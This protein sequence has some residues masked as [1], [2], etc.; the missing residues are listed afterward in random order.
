MNIA[1]ADT[2]TLPLTISTSGDTPA[3]AAAQ[4]FR[5]TCGALSDL[6]SL[7]VGQQN[8]SLV[9]EQIENATPTAQEISN[10]LESLS[11]RTITSIINYTAR[12]PIASDYGRIS[13]FTRLNNLSKPKASNS[14]SR[15][16]KPRLFFQSGSDSGSRWWEKFN[17]YS[18]VNST[19]NEQA[20]TQRDAKS[21]G[22]SFG[23]VIGAD[24]ALRKNIEVGMAIDVSGANFDVEQT[25]TLQVRRQTMVGYG[26]LDVTNSWFIETA[27]SLS[28]I[29]YELTR[30]IDF[31]LAQQDFQE[32][33]KSSSRGT[34]LN[35]SVGTGYQFYL[36]YGT[37]LVAWGDLNA[38]RTQVDSFQEKNANGLGLEI[39]AID[40]YVG[41]WRLGVDTSKPLY[42]GWGII[43]P[44]LSVLYVSEFYNKGRPVS[45]EFVSDPS[46]NKFNFRSDDRD[47]KYLDINLGISFIFQKGKSAYV[48]YRKYF[49]INEYSQSTFSLGFR[50]EF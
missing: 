36:P 24:T 5:N 42:Q 17:F 48:S 1:H 29:S 13:G 31:S 4:G 21:V 41:Q 18:S 9:C 26:S 12:T 6:V 46:D 20:R 14:F 11:A 33:A 19:S 7:D 39:D 28:N 44:Q 43:M 15:N 2:L 35:A 34:Q 10:A 8:F 3:G 40:V 47:A 16:V 38:V 30:P 25:T 45:S 23:F 49:F 22:S 37:S 32:K 27:G 50:M